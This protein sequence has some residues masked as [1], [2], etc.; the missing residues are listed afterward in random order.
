MRLPPAAR[1]ILERVAYVLYM[2]LLVCSMGM[3][4]IG[5]MI[6]VITGDYK[7]LI[8]SLS[9]LLVTRWLHVQGH[10]HWHFREIREAID[11]SPD[12]D[13]VRSESEIKLSGEVAGLLTRMDEEPDVWER[14]EIR[15]EI[16]TRLAA[17]PSL[18]EEF[19]D[20]IARHPGL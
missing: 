5:W 16:A 3:T 6:G 2:G 14:G 4:W 13:W 11:A 18:R 17:A 20:K 7:I 1:P 8:Y 12:C 19:A 9:G 15:R 10:T